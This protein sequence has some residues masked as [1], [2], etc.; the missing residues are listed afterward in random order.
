MVGIL[1]DLTGGT[2]DKPTRGVNFVVFF[3]ARDVT[4][5]EFQ[6]YASNVF[7]AQD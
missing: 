3:L 5:E 2:C 1:K 6:Q 4:S 7:A